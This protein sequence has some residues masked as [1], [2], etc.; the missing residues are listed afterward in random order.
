MILV[1]LLNYQIIVLNMAGKM[2]ANI[3]FIKKFN[4][5]NKSL[6]TKLK[7]RIIKSTNNNN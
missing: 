3:N 7:N 4:A 5:N 2:N 6:N 1:C